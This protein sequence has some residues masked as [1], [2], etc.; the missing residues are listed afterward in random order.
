MK[1]NMSRSENRVLYLW[2][3]GPLWLKSE[4]FGSWSLNFARWN[5]L[6]FSTLGLI[7]DTRRICKA[8]YLGNRKW[9]QNKLN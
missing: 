6:D 1:N 3:C 2:L 9:R 8:L 7:Y 4:G 5:K